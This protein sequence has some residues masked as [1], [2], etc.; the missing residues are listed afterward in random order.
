LLEKS[1]KELWRG[2]ILGTIAHAIWT[3]AKP[4]LAYEQ[5]WSDNNYNV[6]DTEGTFGTIVFSEDDVVGVF[7]DSHSP[8]SPYKS[9]FEL[10]IEQ[11]FKGM[12]KSLKPL[13]DTALQFMLQDLKGATIPIITSA[14]WSAKDHLAANEPW[15][16]V[17]E[18]GAHIIRIQLLDTE[19]AY[20][21]W[22]EN[23]NFSTQQMELLK[24]LFER[25]LASNNVVLNVDELKVLVSKGNKG[26]KQSKELLKS[27]GIAV[28]E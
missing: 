9:D 27:I 5:S 20:S 8:R 6:S 19:K 11:F 13:A 18:H 7:F 3:A 12:Q 22:K 26:I 15:E 23:Y 24:S 21:E 10:S 14:F 2:C 28:A 16:E 17:S 4:E 1:P 25:R